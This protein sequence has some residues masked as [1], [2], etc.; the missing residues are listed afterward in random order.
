MPGVS[1]SAAI[2]RRDTMSKSGAGDG[3][4]M[5]ADVNMLITSLHLTSLDHQFYEP[6][7]ICAI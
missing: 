6:T 1:V 2:I 3:A 5:E 4:I 7:I